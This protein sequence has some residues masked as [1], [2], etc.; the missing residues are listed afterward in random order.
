MRV[1]PP[2]QS[3]V[4]PPIPRG[5]GWIGMGSIGLPMAAR[6]AG[7]GFEVW[8]YDASPARREAATAAGI[9]VAKD[10]ADAAAHAGGLVFC[11]VRTLAQLEATLLGED[12]VLRS[13]VRP[14]AVVMSSVGGVALA[15]LEVR[16]REDGGRILD[17]PILGNP[18]G[19]AAGTLTIVVSGAPDAAAEARP[20]FD[21]FSRAVVVLGEAVGLAQTVKM[22]SQLRQ[23]IGMLATLEGIDLAVRRGA[24]EQAVLRVL[25]ET[26]PS[27]ATQNWT[28]ARS[29]W[30]GRDRSTS[31]GIFAKDL[32]AAV[33]DAHAAGLD[34]EL[35]RE[36]H[37][38]IEA[39]IEAPGD[40]GET[41]WGSVR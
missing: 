41:T 5:V 36:A 8:G 7:A 20:I 3:S 11:V 38:L 10:A 6:V 22:V 16:V 18:A 4:T 14:D 21:S 31:L 12:G 23:V 25:N 33:S 13:G 19:A 1:D 24:D 26:E 28:Y 39:R 34:I 40:D 37:R 17:A 27:W 30:L 2:G 32:A 15:A 9:H 29:L 35:T